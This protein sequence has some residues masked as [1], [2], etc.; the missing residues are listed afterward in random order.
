MPQT[1]SPLRY[2]GG[3]SSIVDM[4][5]KIIESNKLTGGHYAEPYAGGA[6]LALS[7]L[8]KGKVHEIHLNDLDKAVW[9]FW[10]AILNNTCEFI[11][12]INDT[13]ITIDEWRKQRE[14]QL[15]PE[16]YSEFELGFSSFF[17]NRTNRSGVIL[18]AGVIGGIN[19]DGEYKLGCR[20]NKDGLIKKIKRISK[21]KHRIHLYN[22]D[23]IDFIKYMDDSFDRD[24]FLCIDPPYYNKGSTLYTNFYEPG[25][26]AELSK[27]ILSVMKPWMLTY[28][29]AVEISDLYKSRRQFNFNLNYSA[30]TKRVGTEL[31]VVSKGLRVSRDLNI[32]KK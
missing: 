27:V 13:E 21:Y 12:K 15:N 28:D 18:K 17:L 22:Q 3:K 1:P 4:V 31:L 29:N 9:S 11:D 25:D 16:L 5:S 32:F 19:Q 23:A 6:G 8:F 14:I 20:F 7:L 26:H 24:V 2:P 10:N 30:A